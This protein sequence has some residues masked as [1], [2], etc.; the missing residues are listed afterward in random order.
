[1]GKITE[2]MR[3]IVHESRMCFVATVNEDGTPNLSPKGSLAVYD[4]NH[5]VFANIASPDTVANLKRLPVIEINVVDIFLRRG[6]RFKGTVELMLEG[7]KEYK[8]V[9]EPLWEEN[10]DTYPVFEVIKVL[11]EQ[12]REVK[13]PAYT[14]GEGITEEILKDAFLKKYGVQDNSHAS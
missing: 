1:M 13:S 8:S 4:D 14:F 9:A 7:T 2:E 10:G 5:L 6:Y 3:T 12:A 11:V